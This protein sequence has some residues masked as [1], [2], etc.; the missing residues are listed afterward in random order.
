[1]SANPKHISKT[2]GFLIAR[3]CTAHHYRARQLLS[4]IGIHIGQEMV[5]QCLWQE[6]K[7]TQSQLANQ[8][9]VQLQTVHKMVRRMEKAEL[10]TKHEDEQDRRASRVH[11]TPKACELQAAIED[12]WAQLERET[13]ADFTVEEQY[14][15]KRLLHKIEKNLG[16]SE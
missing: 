10:V 7:L 5:L 15:L 6:D 16:K 8:I 13:L 4:D 2:I 1:M 9:G 11:L 12:A 3:V 14:I